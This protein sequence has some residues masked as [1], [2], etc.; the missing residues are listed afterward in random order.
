MYR[1][2]YTPRIGIIQNSSVVTWSWVNLVHSS[3]SNRGIPFSG[4]KWISGLPASHLELSV[5]D[6]F[7][8]FQ[9][10]CGDSHPPKGEVS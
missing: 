6:R 10:A 8:L 2:A 4:P 7:G 9:G 1:V 5:K 3:I